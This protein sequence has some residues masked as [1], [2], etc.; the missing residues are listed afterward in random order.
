MTTRTYE[1]ATSAP[2]EQPDELDRGI[3]GQELATQRGLPGPSR[4]D[5]QNRLALSSFDP[6]RHP[7]PDSSF[8][9]HF[10]FRWAGHQRTPYSRSRVMHIVR[11]SKS[12]RTRARRGPHPPGL[13]RMVEQPAPQRGSWVPG[14]GQQASRSRNDE[15]RDTVHG[16]AATTAENRMQ[17][18]R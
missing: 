2:T 1:H 5:D 16:R 12:S 11:W 14:V 18:P 8:A 15:V 6:G 13:I 7:L 9:R 4:T 10:G 17:E 3:T